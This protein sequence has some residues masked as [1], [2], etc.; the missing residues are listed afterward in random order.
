MKIFNSLAAYPKNKK[1]TVLTLGNFDGVHLGHQYLIKSAKKLALEI[2]AEL[3]VITFTNHPLKVLKPKLPI[4]T[5]CSLAHKLELL[6]SLAVD[7]LILLDFTEEL[8]SMTPKEFIFNLQQSIFLKHLVLGHDAMIGKD[9]VGNSEILKNLSN[10]MNFSLTYLKPYYLHD[11]LV[12]S[13]LIR[14]K[15]SVGDLEDVELYLGRKFSFYGQ[16]SSSLENEKYIIGLEEPNIIL[17][18]QARY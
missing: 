2:D 15:I 5:I 12:S 10:S 6:Q 3:S 17:P 13:S 8:A 16:I 9:R 4:K 7:N 11:K 18:P 14:R 1:P